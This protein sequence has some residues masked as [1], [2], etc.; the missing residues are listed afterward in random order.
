MDVAKPKKKDKL[1]LPKDIDY[2]ALSKVSKRVNKWIDSNRL[3][4]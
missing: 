2:Y 3:I 1:K 4:D